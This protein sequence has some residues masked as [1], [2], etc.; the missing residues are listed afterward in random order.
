MTA[1]L[2]ALAAI[3]GSNYW[4]SPPAATEGAPKDELPDVSHQLYV[5]HVNSTPREGGAVTAHSRRMNLCVWAIAKDV[6][7]GRAQLRRIAADILRALWAAEGTFQALTGYGMQVPVTFTPRLDLDKAG[8]RI[9]Q[10]EFSIDF[11]SDHTAP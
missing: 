10:V 6:G 1:V 5:E 8:F 9:G 2:A 3:G 4:T 7:N 11:E